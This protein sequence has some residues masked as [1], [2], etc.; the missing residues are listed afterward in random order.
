MEGAG[1][2]SLFRGTKLHERLHIMAQVAS[3]LGSAHSHGLV[4]R[5]L[6]PQN[7]LV[8]VHGEAKLAD[9]G[10]GRA[11]EEE[12]QLPR[13]GSTVG[14]ALYMAPEQGLGRAI[15]PRTDLYSL[16]VMLYQCATNRLPFV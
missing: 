5:D 6:K 16:G 12:C 10:L 2:P 9:F 4:H 1:S 11:L 3:G 7:V 15:D 13:E 14:S 8:S